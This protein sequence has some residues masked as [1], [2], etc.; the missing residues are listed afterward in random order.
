MAHLVYAQSGPLTLPEPPARISLAHGEAPA[1]DPRTV[2][3]LAADHGPQAG[4]DWAVV[5]WKG[6][7]QPLGKDADR[8][9][10]EGGH[11]NSASG[12]TL[13]PGVLAVPDPPV[14]ALWMLTL[15][16]YR[17]GGGAGWR[18]RPAKL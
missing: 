4:F 18:R 9:A 15:V 6:L 5:D 1:G 12:P 7:G 11:A 13:P 16:T 17:L 3:R 14:L 2:I 10:N 8:D